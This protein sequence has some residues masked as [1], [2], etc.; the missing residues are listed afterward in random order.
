M[1][2]HHDR[3]LGQ[4]RAGFYSDPKLPVT[5]NFLTQTSCDPKLPD[6]KLPHWEIYRDDEGRRR[7]QLKQEADAQLNAGL[8]LQSQ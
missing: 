8:S 2:A 6:P 5:P 3:I 7:C 4:I 1:A